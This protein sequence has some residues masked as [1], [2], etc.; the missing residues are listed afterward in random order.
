MKKLTKLKLVKSKL[1]TAIVMVCT[2]A[3][4]IPMM[5]TPTVQAKAA[6]AT[7]PIYRLYNPDNGEHLYT[8]DAN[9][10]RVL[11]YEHN[12]GYEGIAWYAPNGTG[13]PVY[14]L[15]NP[16]LYNH[17]YTTDT[18]E[19]A[20]LTTTTE[21][22]SDNNG[23]PVFYSDGSIPVYR[24]YNRELQ[25]MHHL[26]TDKNE[27]DTL[28]IHGWTQ[29]GEALY[30]RAIGSPII[31]RYWN[32][33]GEELSLETASNESTTGGGGGN[34]SGSTSGGSSE[35]NGSSGGS[36]SSGHV[37]SYTWETSGNTR[38]LKCS[39]GATKGVTETCYNGYWGYYDAEMTTALFDE[40]N[41]ARQEARYV[42][43]DAL[44]NVIYAGNVHAVSR[45]SSLDALATR[46]AVE[47]LSS[48]SH[49]GKGTSSY[50]LGENLAKGYNTI[51]DTVCAW[52]ASHD[53]AGTMTFQYYTRAGAAW[54]WYDQDGTGEN[55]IG[56]AVME[57]DGDNL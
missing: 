29:E 53:H 11:Y 55:L 23:Q 33:S 10:T 52:A 20:V 4:A 9:E 1:R 7:V 3:L 16:V 50:Y 39:C 14:R 51:I 22:V 49:E 37:H 2:L 48:W 46:R 17:L 42:D 21:W 12:W 40:C 26:T 15:Y 45:D 18:N 30:A 28:P 38:T 34:S 56:V 31:T 32:E 8:T 19:V 57:Y 27:Y 47:V 25:G 44:G 13:T 41:R 5:L 35:S 36:G 6:D 54:F 24:V 43:R